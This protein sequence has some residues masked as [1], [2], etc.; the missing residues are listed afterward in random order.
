MIRTEM[1]AIYHVCGTALRV[2]LH[3]LCIRRRGLLSQ[4]GLSMAD[5]LALSLS[6]S[7]LMQVIPILL[8]FSSCV[9]NLLNTAF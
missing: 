2:F 6:D 1:K 4:E 3:F 9:R 8:V 7:R 5:V